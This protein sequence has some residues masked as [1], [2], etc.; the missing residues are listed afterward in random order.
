MTGLQP[1]H[2]VSNGNRS[3]RLPVADACQ[4]ALA[5]LE[6]EAIEEIV[7]LG[8][9]GR[10]AEAKALGLADQPIEEFLPLHV[11]P[12]L[13]R[14][15]GKLAAHELRKLSAVTQS[16]ILPQVMRPSAAPRDHRR[17]GGR[18]RRSAR[19]IHEQQIAQ[20]F[21]LFPDF[22]RD[23]PPQFM[24]GRCR[25]GKQCVSDIGELASIEA[26]TVAKRPVLRL[27]LVDRDGE[28]RGDD[29]D[30]KRIRVRR[31]RR[32]KSAIDR[33]RRCSSHTRRFGRRF[34]VRLAFCRADARAG[35]AA[36]ARAFV[37]HHHDLLFDLIVLIVVAGEIDKLAFV[38]ETLEDHD[39]AAAYFVAAAAADAGLGIDRD[40]KVG[41]PSAA[42][43]RFL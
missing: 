20:A 2:S 38:V 31:G 33:R 19:R 14:K 16:Q 12:I 18:Q 32:L 36:D 4:Q 34:A 23:V 22:K 26:D 43:A 28:D 40:E 17:I 35:A 25:S 21:L 10:G 13:L 15:R 3:E 7:A 8:A 42:V 39:L 41:L 30:V 11:L 27:G 29:M 1:A 24:Q 9:D 5:I 37:V 6:T